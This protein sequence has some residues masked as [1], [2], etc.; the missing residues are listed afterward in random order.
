MGRRRRNCRKT[1]KRVAELE[2]LGVK[3]KLICIGKKGYQFFK[4]RPQYTI[5]S[6]CHA[7][8]WLLQ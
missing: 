2:A 4:R 8:N 7:G 5:E 6:A 1:E 3:V